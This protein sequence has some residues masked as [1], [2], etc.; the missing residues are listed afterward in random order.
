MAWLATVLG[1]AALAALALWLGER[2]RRRRG[3]AER[4]D[5]EARF[6]AAFHGAGVG[7]ALVEA[8]GRLADFN[9]VLCRMSGLDRSALAGRRFQELLHPDDRA[10]GTADFAALVR[11]ERD[12]YDV[13]RRYVRPDG[14][15]RHVR[16]AVSAIRDGAGRFQ[17][18]VAVVED[19]TDRDELQ[20]RLAA[21]DRMAS[22]GGLAA[23]VAHELNNPLSYVAGNL[24]YAREA[25]AGGA[26]TP[27]EALAQARQALDEANEGAARVRQIVGDL[28]A[29]S[30]PG[31]DRR[32]PVD[33]AAAVR[34]A[35]NLA[36]G[37]L[38]N[39]ARA[40]LDLGPVPPVAGD[41]ARFGQ[42]VLNLIVN[43][44]QAIPEGRPE[45]NEVRLA[46]ALEPDGRVRLDVIDTGTGIPPDVLPHIFDPFF[47]TKRH[48]EGTGLGLAICQ[49]T[50]AAMGGEIAVRT[51]PG[52][53]TTMT[54][55]LPAAPVASRPL[56]TAALGASTQAPGARARVLVVD[57]EPYVGRTMR[58]IL[59]AQHDVEVIES[60]DVALERLARPPPPDVI[61]CDL[62]MPGTTGMELHARLL[63][64]DP[65]AALRV[66]FVTGGALH[67]PA[68]RFLASVPNPVLEKPFATD[69]L[70]AVVAETLRRGLAAL[71]AGAAAPTSGR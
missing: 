60:A 26:A 17:Q 20:L 53:G 13:E 46:A 43:A 25:L 32:E 11:G 10:E 33:V 64:R 28:R 62:M 41:P 44:A 63:A 39:R 4:R 16:Y 68:R 37:A 24:A 8:D 14:A 61:L 47:S 36:S 51:A 2:T 65:A 40:V 56:P 50:V 42:V 48:G 1:A 71:P 52:A 38:R 18:A 6:A 49:R 21:A 35:L 9:E 55:R 34:S 57:D 27:P 59:G 30:R 19:L 23:G 54:V 29:L 58:R 67:E 12:R 66:V 70:R 31:A 69:L 22:L 5:S 45:A 7:M 3:E 15:A